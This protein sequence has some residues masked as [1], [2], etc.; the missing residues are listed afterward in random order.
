MFSISSI[1][2]V[3]EGGIDLYDILIS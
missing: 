3:V 2:T 1:L